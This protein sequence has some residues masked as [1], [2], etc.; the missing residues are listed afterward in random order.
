MKRLKIALDCDDVLYNCNHYAVELLNKELDEALDAESITKW[1]P[2][3]NDLGKRLKYFD[4]PEFYE[5]EP[6]IK[7]AKDFVHRLSQ[8][9]DVYII[10]SIPAN[11]AGARVARLAQDFPE[12]PM[13]NIFIGRKKGMIKV[14]IL[15]DDGPHNF[16]DSIAEYCVLYR[17]PWNSSESGLMSV[18]SYAEF[19]NFVDSLLKATVAP[20][21][22][23]KMLCLIGPSASGKTTIADILCTQEEG[24]CKVTSCTT[25]PV[26]PDDQPGTYNYLTK[27]EFVSQVE[28]GQFAEYNEYLGNLYGTR[29]EDIL[30]SCLKGIVVTVLDI[31]GAMAMKRTFG[32]GCAI[33][34]IDRPKEQII[35]SILERDI[36]N[37][38]KLERIMT[39]D[40]ES[41]NRS[42][43]DAVI[44][45]SRSFAH[46]VKQ[47]KKVAGL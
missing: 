7:G 33:V 15:L 26:R 20:K 31:R 5:N 29:F 3:G 2:L 42:Y 14:D 4:D 12:I 25:R 22:S 45:N 6:L 40:N 47:I 10:T 21:E 36:S 43:A 24:F 37:E 11:C 44:D 1:G 30:S 39:V 16:T 41:S 34:F 17:Q 13:E 27:K 9:A 38:D 46:A 28:N 8:V 32:A 23:P 35:R 18:Y 19:L